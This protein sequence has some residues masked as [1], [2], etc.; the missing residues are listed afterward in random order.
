MA[1]YPI[2]DEANNT[3]NGSGNV[4]HILPCSIDQDF[5]APTAQYFHPTPIENAKSPNEVAIDASDASNAPNEDVTIMAA[6]FRGRG[7]LCA[8]DT[9]QNTSSSND[10]SRQ[11]SPSRRKLSTLPPTLVGVA[12]ERACADAVNVARSSATRDQEPLL[13]VSQPL[14][15]VETFQHLYHWHHEHDASKVRMSE[16]YKSDRDCKYG[17]NA[18]LEWC[19]VSHAVS[20]IL[21]KILIDSFDLVI[22]CGTMTLFLTFLSL[23][24]FSVVPSVFVCIPDS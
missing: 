6:Q 12:F 18:V 23:F 13:P 24:Y 19:D 4:C 3:K 17:L 1:L 22:L 2:C 5:T 16:L 20:E 21:F 8:V 15:V 7:L 9:P 14:Q 11:Q 10:A